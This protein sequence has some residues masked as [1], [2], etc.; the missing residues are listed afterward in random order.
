MLECDGWKLK[1]YILFNIRKQQLSH[2]QPTIKGINTYTI[3][4]IRQYKTVA[5][6]A[7][8]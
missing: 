4:S 6:V 8:K 1:I 5:N 3:Y 2:I 7:Y